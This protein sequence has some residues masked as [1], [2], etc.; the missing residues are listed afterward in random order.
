MNNT[1]LVEEMIHM[2]TVRN[3]FAAL[4]VCALVSSLVPGAGRV[5]VARADSVITIAAAR[6]DANGDGTP[7]LNGQTV[8]VKG[9]ATIDDG[10][11]GSSYTSTYLQDATG[12]INVYNAK[13]SPVAVKAGDL[14]QATG[15][16]MMYSGAMELGNAT[17]Q[18]ISS[19]NPLPTPKQ[20]TLKDIKSPDLEGTL[21]AFSG[22]V[23]STGGPTSSGRL[24]INI[25]DDDVP[26]FTCMPFTRGNVDVTKILKGTRYSF[27][28][29]A[30]RYLDST[31]GQI[32]YE[33]IIRGPSDIQLYVEEKDT[34]APDAVTNVVL[35]SKD[36]VLKSG[37]TK[38]GIDGQDFT[39]TWTPSATADSTFNVYRI[40]ILPQ[41]TALDVKN[42]IPFGVVSGQTSATFTGTDDIL[43]D[44]KGNLWLSGAKYV[45]YV[46][47]EDTS[48]NQSAA[49]ASPPGTITVHSAPAPVTLTSPTDKS[50][51]DTLT[52]ILSWSKS[53]E[54]Q[55]YTLQLSGSSDFAT[56][57]KEI[58]GLTDPMA[59]PAKGVLASN[60]TY[61]WRVAAVNASGTSDWSPVFSF[62]TKKAQVTITLT[63]VLG[64][65]TM[66]V[67]DTAGT[68]RTETLEAPATLGAGN[69]TLVPIRAVAEALGGEVTWNA[70]SRTATVTV[71]SN[72]LE[73]TIGKGTA[74]LNGSAKPIDADPK[75]VPVITNGRT[76]LPLRFVTESLGAE[77]AFDQTTKTITITFIKP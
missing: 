53:L 25:K 33:A 51:V 72:T 50:V 31:S 32:K 9:I 54:A 23:T 5:D 21:V 57:T 77:V 34:T 7:D 36:I 24:F 61:Y 52:P 60:Q 14:V 48:M 35:A 43:R 11:I 17:M 12:G 64:S 13:K 73:L 41:G 76:M 67:T 40:F 39:I 71:G 15:T 30:T 45:A 38:K 29:I 49:A 18:V 46:I 6:V 42:D 63:L 44:G 22:I 1:P 62:T 10:I 74:L 56:I 27:V 66:H 59:T 26:D 69:R 2:R 19:G 70:T 68:S 37:G 47:A 65:T 75:V 20:V 16:I 28:G 58:S 3:I 55:S 8:T 4:L